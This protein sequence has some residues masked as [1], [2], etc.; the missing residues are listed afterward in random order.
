MQSE[1]KSVFDRDGG[2]GTL[3]GWFSS[4]ETQEMQTAASEAAIF[5]AEVK[6][7]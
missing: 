2:R 4:A 7:G 3:L 6:R 1:A 5:L